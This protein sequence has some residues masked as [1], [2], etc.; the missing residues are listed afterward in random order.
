MARTAVD[1]ETK[2]AKAVVRA[3]IVL[4]RARVAYLNACHAGRCEVCKGSG[5]VHVKNDGTFGDKWKADWV[6]LGDKC[7]ACH[8]H[9][10]Q[11]CGHN[12]CQK[13]C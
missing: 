2:A 10:V 3:M 11:D 13:G 4:E 7:P 8:G 9:G 1:P 6:V 12:P 5:E